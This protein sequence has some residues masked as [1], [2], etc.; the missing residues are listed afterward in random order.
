MKIRGAA[1][2]A[3]PLCG[4]KV[5]DI[6]TGKTKTQRYRRQVKWFSI[7]TVPALIIYTVFWIIPI[8]ISGGISFTDWSGLTKLSEAHF[9]GLKNYLNLF[10]DSILK[11]AIK[12]NLIY[13][14]IMILIVPVV[15]FILAYIIE[16]FVR[17]KAFW[18]TISYLPAILPM[19]VTV[20]LW[21]WMY[22]PQYGLLNKFLELI[23]LG[24]YTTGWLTNTSTA[25]F[26]VTFVALWKTIPTYFVLF[27]AGLQSVPAELT[28]AA[29]LDGAGRF[30]V[31][32][33]VTIPCMRRIIS[34]VYVLVFIDVFRVFDL[35]YTMTNG[36]PGY[37]S[38]EMILTYGYK[39]TFANSNAGYGMSMMTVLIIFV[40]ICS[41][42]QM[43]IQNRAEE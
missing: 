31:I 16:T 32:R 23:G 42:V 6:N 29:V 15:A 8:L 38:T 4:K 36:G 40:M 12:N 37:Y 30:Q 9:V 5:F 24:E 11:T 18:R 14:V 3:A 17:R 19:I 33:N 2:F 26:A 1:V 43:K 25:L 41:A 35:V 34:I 10:K 21:K 20:L 28:E 27:M 13:G 7:F 39:T 22:N